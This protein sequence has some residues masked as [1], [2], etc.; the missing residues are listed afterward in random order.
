[1]ILK[2]HLRAGKISQ[3]RQKISP[4]WEMTDSSAYISKDIMNKI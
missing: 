2:N 4:S 1:M 3:I